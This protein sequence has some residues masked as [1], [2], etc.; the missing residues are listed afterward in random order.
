MAIPDYQGLMLPV[1]K[2]VAD[3]QE[4]RVRD[5][6]DLLAKEL[7]LTADELELKLPSGQQ[8]V[9]HNRVGWA[10]TFLK[11]RRASGKSDQRQSSH[12]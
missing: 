3:G 8:P 4:H 7:S 11:G 5:L 9:F 2:A 6:Y 12:H 1:L 10:K